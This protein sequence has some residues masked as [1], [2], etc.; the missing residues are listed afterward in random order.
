M[1]WKVKEVMDQRI[2]FVAR[3]VSKEKT[4]SELCQ[5]YGISRTTGHHWIKRY[6]EVGSFAGLREKSRRP[7]QSPRRTPGW[8]E[9]RVLQKRVAHG[10]GARKLQPLLETEGVKVSERT[11]NRI[12][13]RLGAMRREDCHRPA[14][15][16]FE[17]ERPNELWQMDFKGEYV[18]RGGKNCYPLSMIDDHSRFSV[19]LYG[20]TGTSYQG[21]R[22]CVIRTFQKYG[23]PEAM[24]MDHGVP[25]WGA[26]NRL[27]LTRLSVDLMEQGIRLYYSGVGHPQT[28]GKVERFHRTL[29]AGIRHRGGPPQQFAQWGPLL[30]AFREE[31]NQV[32]P[33]EALQMQ[34]P[35]HLAYFIGET[36]DLMDLSDFFKHYEGDGR[37]NRP[38]HPRMMVKILLYG[39]ATGVFSSRKLARKMTEDVAFRVLAAG[40]SPAHRTIA[41]FRQRHLIE[42]QALFVQLVRIAAEAG[43]VKLGAV[44]VDGSKVK[45]N[46]SKRK[47]MTYQRMSQA[48]KE[49]EQEIAE[50]L[51][52]A[53]RR[54]A[55][56]DALYGPE[57]SGDELPEELRRREQ[58]LVKIKAAKQRLERRQ[59]EEDR[60]QGRHE[61][62]NRKNPRGGRDFKREFG[63]VEKKKQDNFTD[64]ESRI[65]K[66]ST[67]G[68]QQSYNTQIAVDEG[69]QLIVATG[70]TSSAAD[71]GQLMEMVEEVKS[72]TGIYP[73]RVS[74][75]L[76]SGSLRS[77]ILCKASPSNWSPR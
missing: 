55:Q 18:L 17:R 43:V 35:G 34:V 53:A 69:S 22:A 74:S 27:G 19:G 38:F 60:T 4:V 24:L 48:E 7:H 39:Y 41:E 59:E 28:Q 40:N 62:D 76:S 57:N 20:L 15:S 49:L 63:E 52:E 33:H 14:L 58:R 6:R 61:G 13:K 32:R 29:S 72:V 73:E 70:M 42:F 51:E 45:A 54:D 21:V 56:E 67:E 1:T 47:A 2:E 36:V 37:R 3:A 11:I 44:A 12:L 77:R 64:P 71:N 75:Y 66:T 68:F 65:M 30:K 50:L 26:A 10:W 23:V 8:V 46:A 31:Y 9:H 5:A 16:R 25:W